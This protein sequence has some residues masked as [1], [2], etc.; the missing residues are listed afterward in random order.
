V[1]GGVEDPPLFQT[2]FEPSR[3]VPGPMHMALLAYEAM[4]LWGALTMGLAVRWVALGFMA[5]PLAFRAF[6]DA[7]AQIRIGRSALFYRAPGGA[8]KAYAWDSV[9]RFD[10]HRDPARSVGG[11]SDVAILQFWIGPRKRVAFEMAFAELPRLFGAMGKVLNRDKWGEKARELA[12]ET[13]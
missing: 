7:R 9:T 10:A 12:E 8:F 2:S 11:L 1:T 6:F 5:G 4:F 13:P 3:L